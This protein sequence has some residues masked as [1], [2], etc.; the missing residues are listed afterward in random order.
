MT[1]VWSAQAKKAEL[2]LGAPR[3]LFG[4]ATLAR[5]YY[6]A[7]ATTTATNDPLLPAG[8]AD[9]HVSS[10]SAATMTATNDPLRPAGYKVVRLHEVESLETRKML[11][12]QVHD[13]IRQNY[14]KRTHWSGGREHIS[15]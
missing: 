1:R 2:G 12:A 14:G 15:K 3:K 7:A 13:V 5:M 8:K 9:T 6:G 10:S 4:S 11:M